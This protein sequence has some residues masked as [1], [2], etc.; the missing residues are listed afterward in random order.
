MQTTYP[1]DLVPALQL[2]L[3]AAESDLKTSPRDSHKLDAVKDLRDQLRAAKIA[4]KPYV[5]PTWACC[6]SS[7]GPVC[8]HRRGA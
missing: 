8:E 7:I 3:A 4:A 2:K 6:T 1:L 5:R